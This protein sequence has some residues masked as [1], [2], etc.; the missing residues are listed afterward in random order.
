METDKLKD[1]EISIFIQSIVKSTKKGKTYLTFLTPKRE[2]SSF[3]K[4][5][6]AHR[7]VFD[8]NFKLFEKISKEYC[9]MPLSGLC[10]YECDINGSY[11][12][13]LTTIYDEKGEILWSI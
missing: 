8:N 1:V 2:E 3:F 6:V 13:R 7:Q 4:G 12:P 5:A 9:C 11:V 10:D